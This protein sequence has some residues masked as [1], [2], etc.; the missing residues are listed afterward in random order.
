MGELGSIF[1]NLY[2]RFILRDLFAKM[3]PG[4]IAILATSSFMFGS[5][6][7]VYYISAELNFWHWILLLAFSWI[8][9]FI[10]QQGGISVNFLRDDIYKYYKRGEGKKLIRYFRLE[11]KLLNSYDHEFK[12]ARERVIVLKE[13]CGNVSMALIYSGIFLFR[14]IYLHS[15]HGASEVMIGKEIFMLVAIL[16]SAI[17]LR[18]AHL[19][20][21][22][23]ERLFNRVFE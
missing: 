17:I 21:A 1:E 11:K 6:K 13:A 9:G 19:Y 18:K 7:C 5:L 12:Q 22:T 14:S 8:V 15:R 23:R 10:L 16:V 2:S 4:F 3:A 20:H